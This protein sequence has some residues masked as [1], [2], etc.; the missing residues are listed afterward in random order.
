MVYYI[1][2]AQKSLVPKVPGPKSPQSQKFL[3]PKVPWPKCPR[4]QVRW[5]QERFWAKEDGPK[6]DLVPKERVPSV[7]VPSEIGPSEK[8]PIV[9]GPNLQAQ[10]SWA[11]RCLGPKGMQANLDP[12]AAPAVAKFTIDTRSLQ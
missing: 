2:W 8:G 9:I 10:T 12:C 4:A 11:Q 3:G 5:V 1:K 7:K 6:R